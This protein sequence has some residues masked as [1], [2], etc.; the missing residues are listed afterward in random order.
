MI[1]EKRGVS[2]GVLE[3]E[4]IFRLRFAVNPGLQRR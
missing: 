2:P 3:G 1:D 4:H